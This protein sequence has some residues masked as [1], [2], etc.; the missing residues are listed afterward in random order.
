MSD[1]IDVD[2]K[3]R[4]ELL[5]LLKSKPSVQR[6]RDVFGS[7]LKALIA[8]GVL[9]NGTRETARGT[10]TVALDGHTCFSLGEKTIDDYLYKHGI[11]HDREPRTQ[12]V[13]SGETS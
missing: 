1:L 6:V 11:Q 4:L 2:E 5:K 13:S 8:A 10:Q 3:T 9:V 12:L 7:W